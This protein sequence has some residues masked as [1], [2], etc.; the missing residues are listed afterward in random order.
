M[1]Y[2]TYAPDPRLA[3]YIK[4]YWAL[5]SGGSAG[6]S[7]SERIFP[8]GC[9]EMI[10]HYGDLFRKY[11][12]NPETSFLQ[13]RSFVHGQIKK[14]I[15]IEPTGE[16]GIF[17]VRFHPTGLQP[18]I[19]IYTKE[20]TGQN[21][22]L[23]DIWGRDGGELEDRVLNASSNPERIAMIE[24]F[25]LSRLKVTE[26]KIIEHCVTSIRHSNGSRTIEQLAGDLN[27][28][29]RHLERTF[30]SSVGLSPKLLSRIVRFQNTIQLI[31]QKQF[32]SLTFLAYDGGF[33]DQAHFIKDFKEFT[34]LNPKAYFSENL[35][36]AKY[37]ANE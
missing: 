36:L 15:T 24:T 10:F 2:N 16:I 31:H 7:A 1:N 14:Y 17:S 29:R 26:N 34:G 28:G 19:N 4:Y 20:L 32:S 12:S 22:C 3:R 13:P 21:I 23:Q 6:S 25:L 33:Y 11:D 9:I 35:E 37:F 30:V 8:D 5:E 18:F 27:I